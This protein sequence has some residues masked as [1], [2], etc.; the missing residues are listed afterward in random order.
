MFTLDVHGSLVF[1]LQKASR[2]CSLLGMFHFVALL[3]TLDRPGIA[4]WEGSG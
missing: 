4:S 1:V 2:N 3:E